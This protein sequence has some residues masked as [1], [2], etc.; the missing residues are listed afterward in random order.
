MKLS[1]TRAE[2]SKVRKSSY[3]GTFLG[4]SESLSFRDEG[5][6]RPPDFA[7]PPSDPWKAKSEIARIPHRSPELT[8]KAARWNPVDFLLGT[9]Q[10][11][12][13]FLEAIAGLL[14]LSGAAVWIATGGDETYDTTF[15]QGMWF[16]W[17][18]FFDPGTEM[19]FAASSEHKVKFVAVFFSICG[20][21]FNLTLLGL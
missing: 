7:L 19:G 5:L 14:L 2:Q 3:T 18:M 16:S 8:L 20:F 21:L 13:V 11:Q 17:G 12:L 4:R 1:L 10:G 6:L 9:R 15:A